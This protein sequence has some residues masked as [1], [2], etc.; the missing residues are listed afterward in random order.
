[1]HLLRF[2]HIDSNHQPNWFTRIFR[3]VLFAWQEFKRT[4]GFEKASALGYQT[5]FSLIPA[6]VL[7]FSV[8]QTFGAFESLPRDVTEFIMHQLNLDTIEVPVPG[9]PEQPTEGQSTTTAEATPP[10]SSATGDRLGPAAGKAEK[11]TPQGSQP[12]EQA[13]E[14]NASQPPQPPSRKARLSDIINRLVSGLITKIQSRTVN[15]ISLLWLVVAAMSLAVTLETA[16][17][18]VW[19]S[20]SQRSWLNRIVVYWAVLTLG[21]VLIGLPISVAR[22]ME[23]PLQ[24]IAVSV[25]SSSIAFFVMYY[26]M[27]V[28]PVR[29]SCALLGAL[30]ATGAWELAK[31][32]FGLYLQHAVGYG[33]LYGNLALLP[34]TLFWLWI[35]W[36]IV[37]L[38]ATVTYIVQNA[39]RIEAAARG[40]LTQAHFNMGWVALAVVLKLARAHRRGQRISSDELA[41]ASGLPDRQWHQLLGLLRERGIA[42][43]VGPHDDE[44]TLGT[45]ASELR[46]AEFFDMIEGPL[47]VYFESQWPQEAPHLLWVYHELNS[48]RKNALKDLTVASL[49]RQPTQQPEHDEQPPSRSVAYQIGRFLRKLV[50]RS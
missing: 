11:P 26:W 32:L 18:D 13:A 9:A 43:T 21:P 3:Y 7:I 16:L 40:L 28:A 39:G 48:A 2:A 36:V 42:V 35:S 41:T 14:S 45:D 44:I 5:I 20:Q 46:L 30:F 29:V 49:L 12:A 22:H 19:G 47:P 50:G 37:L 38:G 24:G 27:P 17:N 25:L 6:L 31:W 1:M 33:R 8:L 15:L 23:I 34:V 4:R 10:P